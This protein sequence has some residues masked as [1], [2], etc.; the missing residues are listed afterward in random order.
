VDAIRDSG[1]NIGT[2]N[3][4][5][6]ARFAP[7]RRLLHRQFVGDR[8][9]FVRQ[10]HVVEHGERGLLLWIANGSPLVVELGVDGQGLRDMSFAEWIRHPKALTTTVWRGPDI[11]MLIPTGAAH[12]VWWFWDARGNHDGWYV[13]LEE[14][15][16]CWDDGGAAGV[17]TCDQD[18][19]IWVYPD[20]TWEWKDEDE[21]EE[22]LA[23]PD[24]Y[25]VRDADA[26]RAEGVRMARLVEEGSFPFDGTW[27]DFRPDPGWSPADH[28]PEDWDR[29]R[30]R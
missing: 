13:N 14:P 11:L 28:L 17:D 12:S 2:A 19:D 4:D 7:G 18:L 30:A 16:V 8:L 6:A 24:F 10:A 29:P 3:I 20:R 25:W 23:Y 1:S 21:L 26:V 5:T 27:C 15:G 9:V 22:R